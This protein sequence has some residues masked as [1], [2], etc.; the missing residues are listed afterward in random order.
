M[1]V[2]A[3]FTPEDVANI[4]NTKLRLVLRL[5]EPAGGKLY[6]DEYAELF[7]GI[8][9]ATT[10]DLEKAIKALREARGLVDKRNKRQKNNVSIGDLN[11]INGTVKLEDGAAIILT[12]KGVAVRITMDGKNKV[13][14][15]FERE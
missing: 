12:G 11:G 13:K 9:S 10:R 5:P 14:Y 8:E 15:V 1:N 4:G 2:A 7:N 6:R 3:N